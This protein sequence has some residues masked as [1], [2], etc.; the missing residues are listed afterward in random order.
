[1]S[2]ISGDEAAKLMTSSTYEL[3]D[4]VSFNEIEAI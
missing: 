1:V 4:V 2:N 3:F